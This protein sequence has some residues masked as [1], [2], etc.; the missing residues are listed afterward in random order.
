MKVILKKIVP[1]ALRQV[2]WDYVRAP[3][4]LIGHCWRDSLHFI[5]YNLFQHGNDLNRKERDLIML[6]HIIE[7]GLSFRVRHRFFGKE[8]VRALMRLID[9]DEVLQGICSDIKRD[10]IGALYNY[11]DVNHSIDG[12]DDDRKYI[13]DI[14][15]FIE[16][17]EDRGELG[18]ATIEIRKSDIIAAAREGWGGCL[19][20]RHSIREY[21]V[22]PIPL[23][24]LR[25]AI[26]LAQR[27]PSACNLQP[28]RVHV[29]VNKDK[30]MQFLTYQRGARGF[31]EQVDKLLVISYEVGC[32]VGPRSRNQGYTD[33]GLFAMALMQSCLLQGIATCPLHWAVEEKNDA[34]AR[35]LIQL[36]PS[37]RIVMV[38]SAGLLSDSSTVAR[39]TRC[40]VDKILTI[41]D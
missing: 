13:N 38:M 1:Y 21:G 30:I 37:E 34:K 28:V 35:R 23:V 15:R 20:A 40:D 39:S 17:Q 24:S 3:A 10:A 9:D 25:E 8:V 4:N 19:K 36:P 27:A 12:S 2:V 18:K 14:L 33:G 26:A 5:K 16:K 7:K 22:E 6:T 29:I 11:Y 41:V 31:L 32:L